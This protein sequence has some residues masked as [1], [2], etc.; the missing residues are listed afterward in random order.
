[1]K[2]TFLTKLAVGASIL[3]TALI[4]AGGAAAHGQDPTHTFGVRCLSNGM[5]TSMA[6]TIPGSFYAVFVQKY[7]PPNWVG[8]GYRTGWIATDDFR[9]VYQN[10]VAAPITFRSKAQFALEPGSY[11]AWGLFAFPNGQ[12]GFSYHFTPADRVCTIQ[13]SVFAKA[14]KHAKRVAKPKRLPTKAPVIAATR[15]P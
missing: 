6:S 9:S 7:L 10:P 12:G 3:V 2:R 15:K 14:G 1:M 5:E 8:I 4:S 13:G 11:F